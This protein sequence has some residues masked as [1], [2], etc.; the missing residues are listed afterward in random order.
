M[1]DET[2]FYGRDGTIH[3]TAH[4][5]VEIDAQGLVVAVWFRCQPLPFKQ[6]NVLNQRAVDM[7][8]MYEGHPAPAIVGVTLKDRLGE[9][10]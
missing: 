5:D 7:R 10:E 1:N 2:R 6:V 3:R 8:K 4:L 9:I